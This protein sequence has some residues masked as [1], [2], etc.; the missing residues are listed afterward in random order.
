MKTMLAM[1]LSL[2]L[3]QEDP[4]DLVRK[5]GDQLIEVREQAMEKL[6][7]MGEPARE[8][9]RKATKSE[10][11]EVRVRADL[12]LKTLDVYRDLRLWLAPPTRI[13]LSGEMTLET[14]IRE[15]ER[16]SGQKVA[17]EA[18]PEGKFRIDLKEI[19]FWEAL[20]A[21]CAASGARTPGGGPAG[22]RVYGTTYVRT[23]SRVDGPFC[24]R[25]GGVRRERQFNFRGGTEEQSLAMTLVLGWE[26]SIVPVRSLLDLE[27]AVDDQ[28]LDLKPGIL[29]YEGRVHA[30]GAI[31]AEDPQPVFSE[32]FYMKTLNPP[33]EKAKI[34]PTLTGK[35]VLWIRA[36]PGDL[37]LPPPVAGGDTRETIRLLDKKLEPISEIRVLLGALS[38]AGDTVS[39]SLTFEGADPRMLKWNTALWYLTDQKS[40][41]YPGGVRTSNEQGKFGLEFARLAQDAE[42]ARIVIRLPRRMVQLE[43]PFALMD[44]PVN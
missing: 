7:R 30:G 38:R 2:G 18:W 29:E 28:G 26:R 42:P 9:V 32:G 44:I 33:N 40:R 15:V 34:I 24:V 22:A 23:P 10:D 16:Q 31:S 5:L 35:I 41:R 36:S 21:V 6:L 8:A 12:I 25:L 1:W 43:I 13:T 20:E 37:E 19:P 27:T 39:V 3:P 11:P 17:G 4:A 14:A